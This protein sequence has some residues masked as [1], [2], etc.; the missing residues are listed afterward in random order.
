MN[1]KNTNIYSHPLYTLCAPPPGAKIAEYSHLYDQVMFRGPPAG[2][3][4]SHPGLPSSPSMPETSLEEDWL[5]ST[6]SNGE[7]ASFMS[8]SSEPDD[9]R[10]SSTPRR[11][12]TSACSIPSPKTSP[13]S[14]TSPP[15]QRWS[16]CISAPSEKEEHVYSSIKRHPSF[17]ASSSPS[18][19]SSPS[20]HCHSLGS[21]G[22]QQQG[23]NPTGLRC[24]TP[25]DRLHGPSLGR[26][27]R[28]R[29]LPERS[30]QG[31]SDLTLHDGQQVLVL[32][33]ASALSVL[34]ATQ[35]YLANFKD[36]GEDDDDYVEIRSEDESEQE[37]DKLARRHGSSAVLSNQ[38]RSPAHSHSLPCT[39]VHSCD[40]LRSLDR[41]HLEKYLWSEPQQSQTKIGQSLREKFQCLSSSSFAWVFNEYNPNIGKH[42]AYSNKRTRLLCLECHH[43]TSHSTNVMHLS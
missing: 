13:P 14:P 27:G 8:S 2:P 31:Q 21:L 5:H 17:H 25:T 30:T 6:Y 4:H 32:N 7:L 19:K 38:N 10:A 16:S 29:S 23:K 20:S 24:N 42:T 18:L 41:E 36:D 15:S 34:T 35:N 39:P 43:S 1:R 12:L 11:R 37:Q 9:G 28:Q 40:P 3:H 22:S 26:A 33:R